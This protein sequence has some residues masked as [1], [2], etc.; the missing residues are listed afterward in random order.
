MGL[1]GA[2]LGTAVAWDVRYAGALL[3]V[4]SHRESL[5]LSRSEETLDV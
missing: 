1:L 4:R 3:I 2:A 5:S